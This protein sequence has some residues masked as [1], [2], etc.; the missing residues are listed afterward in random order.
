MSE[1]TIER[2]HGRTARNRVATLVA[3]T[4]PAFLTA[5]VLPVITAGALCWRTANETPS[6]LLL[7][8]AVVAIALIHA[9]ANVLNDYFDA[10]SGNDAN[11]TGRVYPFSGGS[12]F[13][14]NDIL[15][16]NDMFQLGASLLVLGAMLGLVITWA[17]SPLLLAV[18][19][20]GC[21][22][23]VIYSAP[24]CLACR[25]LGDVVIAICF[26]IL[27][28]I[29][30]Q[31][32]LTGSIA[33]AAWWLGVSIGCF[34]AAILWVNSIPDIASDRIAGKLTLPARIGG[35]A[36]AWLLGA[37]FAAGFIALVLSP[38]PRESWLG[39]LGVVPAVIA[40]R[41]AIAGQMIPAMPMTIITHAAV[42]VLIA[43][44]LVLA[45]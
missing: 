38:M 19:I 30:T 18:G 20:I 33:P 5:S 28:V 31:L 10:V 40:S 32:M 6:M 7:T 41:A 45:R 2:F 8:A 22:L 36:A 21:V 24:P 3:A 23:A 13:I 37:W 26:G 39:L 9:G 43:I 35:E 17:S 29:G 27:P 4:R 34:V 16:E 44:G 14:Q 1:P 42:C 15:S 25:G 12:R 11:N